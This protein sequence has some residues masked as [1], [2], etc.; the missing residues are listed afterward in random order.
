MKNNHPTVKPLALMRYLLKMVTR[1]GQLILDPFAGSGTTLI[2]CKQLDRKY[3]GIEMSKE[4]CNI[5]VKRVGSVAG[6]HD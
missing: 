6:F 3:I 5:A 2:A 4:Y 1:K